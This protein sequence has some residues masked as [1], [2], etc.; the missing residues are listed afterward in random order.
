M[1]PLSPQNFPFPWG[2]W[3]PCNT[4]FLWPTAV[5]NPHGISVGWAAF[6]GLASV[7]DRPTDHATQSVTIAS[8][9][10]IY[11][12][13]NA[14]QPNNNANATVYDAVVITEPLQELTLFT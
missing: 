4:W 10:H 8:I 5:L 11:I 3:T 7:T 12:C 9:G 6:V 1:V 2:M 14:M 13:S